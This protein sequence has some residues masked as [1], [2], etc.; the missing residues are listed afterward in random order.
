MLFAHTIFFFYLDSGIGKG[1]CTVGKTTNLPLGLI[2]KHKEIWRKNTFSRVLIFEA[3][4]FKL[5]RHFGRENK[6][7]A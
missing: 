2:K 7:N 4:N 5:L 1:K 3:E 6:K